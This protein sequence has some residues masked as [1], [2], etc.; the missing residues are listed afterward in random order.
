MRSFFFGCFVLARTVSFRENSKNC[1]KVRKRMRCS[2]LIDF[3]QHMFSHI[4]DKA[5]TCDQCDYSCSLRCSLTEHLRTHREKPFACNQCDY[6]CARRINL[7]QHMRTHSGEKPFACNQCDYR[8]SLRSNLTKHMRTH[9]GEKP[10]ACNYYCF[11][12]FLSLSLSLCFSC[13]DRIQ[14]VLFVFQRAK[15]LIKF[16]LI[17]K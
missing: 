17:C 2:L 14:R 16:V 4:G 12:L 9:S 7:T 8:C 6:R 5:F 1:W 15:K 3:D 13:Q 10:L 11:G